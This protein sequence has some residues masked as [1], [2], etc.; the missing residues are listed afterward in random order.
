MCFVLGGAAHRISASSMANHSEAAIMESENQV[1][2]HNSKDCG[3]EWT[4]CH[5]HSFGFPI[6]RS[7][8]GVKKV[9]IHLDLCGPRS[10]LNRCC[11][12]YNAQYLPV[13]CLPML[14]FLKCYMFIDISLDAS[15]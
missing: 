12:V 10:V 4:V 6:E 2:L 3:K 13:S 9:W 11:V 5:G 15:D 14:E 1:Q 8:S 7:L